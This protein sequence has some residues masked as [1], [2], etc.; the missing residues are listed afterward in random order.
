M[1]KK[2]YP[3]QDINDII[4]DETEAFM[5][6]GV[7][8]GIRGH[9]TNRPEGAINHKKKGKMMPT[10]E[11]YDSVAKDLMNYSGFSDVGGSF[12]SIR[13]VANAVGKIT[14]HS[15][16]IAFDMVKD[17]Q[18][19]GRIEQ[20]GKVFMVMKKQEP[21]GP[22]VSPA[23][24]KKMI[25]YMVDAMDQ[26]MD[27]ELDYDSDEQRAKYEKMSPKKLKEEYE[28]MKEYLGDRK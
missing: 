18:R 11:F 17:L 1:S 20:H 24:T 22:K 6:G 13:Q 14:G 4:E 23:E 2:L 27:H 12:M 7:G 16:K 8:S 10:E 25:D 3:D 28:N 26:A 5:K 15:D 21:K 9:K 19:R